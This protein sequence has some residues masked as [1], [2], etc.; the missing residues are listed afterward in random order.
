MDHIVEAMEL[1]DEAKE[2]MPT[3]LTVDVMQQLKYAYD[4]LPKNLYKLTYLE[5]IA[6]GPRNMGVQKKTMIVE[7]QDFDEGEKWC[8]FHIFESCQLPPIEYHGEI[9][10]DRYAFVGDRLLVAT[11]IEPFLKRK[12]E[13]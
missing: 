3:G 13:E 1:L 5:I 7:E 8:W 4:C 11:Y 10:G 12:R 2:K 9:R 6:R